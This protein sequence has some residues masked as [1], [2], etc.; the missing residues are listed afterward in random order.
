MLLKY[1]SLSY[2]DESLVRFSQIKYSN[3]PSAS[4]INSLAFGGQIS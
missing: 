3:T 2:S 1:F 4:N